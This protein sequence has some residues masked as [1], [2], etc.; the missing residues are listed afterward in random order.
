MKNIDSVSQDLEPSSEDNF[1]G[2][3]SSSSQSFYSKQSVFH[4]SEKGK[5]L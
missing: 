5:V 3:A 1:A 4:Y 2:L